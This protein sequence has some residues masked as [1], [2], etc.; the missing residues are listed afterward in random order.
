M[1]IAV[2]KNGQVKELRQRF[3]ILT[4]PRKWHIFDKFLIVKMHCRTPA[5][6]QHMV[7]DDE[8][9]SSPSRK[10]STTTKNVM[11]SQCMQMPL[12]FTVLDVDGDLPD[13]AIAFIPVWKEIFG[14]DNL[15]LARRMSTNPSFSW[16]W[17]CLSK[18]KA[19]SDT[20][21][22]RSSIYSKAS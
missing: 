8:G 14:Q 12:V 19:R 20:K 6:R 22:M 15:R 17:H 21:I 18:R 13:G 10:D 1:Y 5:L 2:D 3:M 9:I 4:K 7:N 16:F 11:T